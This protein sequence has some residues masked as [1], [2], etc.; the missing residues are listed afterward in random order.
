M[1]RWK[2][3]LLGIA[4]G[5]AYAFI[6]MVLVQASHRTVSLG[7]VFALPL[8]MGAI[9]VLFSTKDQLNNYLYYLLLPWVTV[10]TFFY[11]SF[12]SA[13]E[14]MICLVVI[15]GPFLLLGS[16]GAFIFR[17]VRLRQKGDTSKKLYVSLLLP[18]A[19]IAFEAQLLPQTY[20]GTVETAVIIKADKTSVWEQI[21]EVK[22][23]QP[24]EIAP[25]LV[26]LM[27]VPKPI[28]AQLNQESVGGVRSIRWEKGIHFKEVITNWDRGKGFAYDIII[29]PDNI[30]PNTL[31]EHVMIGGQYFDVIRGSYRIESLSPTTQKVILTSTYRISTTLNFYGKFWADYIFN[32]FHEVILKVIRNRSEQHRL[33]VIP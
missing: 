27:G 12:I 25:H 22:E 24:H 19:L 17:L 6:S 23:I 26:H 7:Y 10:M 9:P 30:P 32:D 31:D 16:L 4:A 11:L 20:Y 1:E 15:V 13:F 14:G 18:F 3:L 21:K 29:N 5:V 33:A 2:T 8:L 28:S